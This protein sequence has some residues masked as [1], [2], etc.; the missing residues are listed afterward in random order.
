MTTMTIKGLVF[1]S[2]DAAIRFAEADDAMAI[3]LQN[4]IMVVTPDE[5]RR[6]E[7]LHVPLVYLSS[8]VGEEA[9]GDVHVF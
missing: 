6:L 4:K 2:P 9:L 7:S 5:A 3:R 1:P 8:A